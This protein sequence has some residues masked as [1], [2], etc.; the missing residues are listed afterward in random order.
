HFIIEN[1][2]YNDLSKIKRKL[3]KLI[4]IKKE[5]SQK[6]YGHIKINIFNILIDQLKKKINIEFLKPIL[7]AYLNSKKKLEYNKVFD[8]TYYYE[9]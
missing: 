9:L 2:K 6:N 7:K 4:E 1:E 8:N 5:N 3:E